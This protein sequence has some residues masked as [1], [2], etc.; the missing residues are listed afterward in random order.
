[1]H[2]GGIAT[3]LIAHWPGVIRKPGAITHQPGHVIDLM[4]TCVDVAGATY[5]TNVTPLEGKS[6]APILEG[7]QRRPHEALF[8]EH[9]GN[10]AVRQGRWKLVSRH[11]A[12]WELYNLA[13]DRTEMRD[14]AA[15]HPGRVRKMV[16]L[17]ESWAARCGVVPWER[18]RKS[19]G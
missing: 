1:V 4:A 3:P 2:E 10:R 5:P 9:E 15:R 11:P 19:G 17:Y 14:L 18:F 7:R 12:N 16:A 8:W 13:R 6:L